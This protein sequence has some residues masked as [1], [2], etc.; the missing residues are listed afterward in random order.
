MSVVTVAGETSVKN[1]GSL[2]ERILNELKTSDEIVLDFV[3]VHHVD[4]AVAQLILAAMKS[5]KAQKKVV[6]VH[7]TNELLKRQFV[8]TGIMK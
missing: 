7:N 8:L 6:R 5:A 4:L 2:R 3:D 1:V